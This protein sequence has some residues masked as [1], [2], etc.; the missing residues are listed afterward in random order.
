MPRSAMGVPTGLLRL[1]HGLAT[2]D[3]PFDGDVLD[4]HGID[5][6]WVCPEHHEVRELARLDRALAVLLERGVGAVV[7]SNLRARGLVGLRFGP[8]DA[9]FQIR[10]GAVSRPV[11][12]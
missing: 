10:G 6:R 4:R 9:C 1:V 5:P 3:R 12:G 11:E 2:D 8:L 7:L